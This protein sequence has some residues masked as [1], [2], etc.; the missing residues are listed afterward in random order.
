MTEPEPQPFP[1]TTRLIAPYWASV[2]LSR[3]GEVFYRTSADTELL[4]EAGEHIL[5]QF[6]DLDGI[7]Q[8]T[9]LLVVT[10]FEVQEVNGGTEVHHYSAVE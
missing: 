9:L 5:A 1:G 7:F 8:P 6:P 4:E 2:D 3:G 10:W